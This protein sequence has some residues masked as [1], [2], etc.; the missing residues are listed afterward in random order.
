MLLKKQT[1]DGIRAGDI[2][3]AFRRWKRPTVKEGGTLKTVVGVLSILEV[4]ETTLKLISESDAKKAGFESRA[5][6]LDNLRG[7]EGKLYRVRVEFQGVDPR[8][9]LRKK[10]ASKAELGELLDPGASTGMN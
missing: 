9:A 10:K 8:V 5:A 6:L 4:R 7:R 3:L 2:T 1:L